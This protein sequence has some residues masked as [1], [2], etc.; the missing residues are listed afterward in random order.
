M[1]KAMIIG[2]VGND[3]EMQY[4]KN[5]AAPVTTLSIATAEHWKDSEGNKQEQTDWHRVVAWGGIAVVCC[6]HLKKGDKVYIEGKLRTRKWKD[7]EGIIRYTTE[8]IAREMEM[9]GGQGSKNA[10]NISQNSNSEEPPL[11]EEVPF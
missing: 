10:A 2:N 5:S 3:P 6:E 11:P 7:Q 1:N 4:T 9:L 8:I